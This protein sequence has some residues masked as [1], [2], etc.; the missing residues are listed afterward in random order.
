MKKYIL[1]KIK[2]LKDL[3]Y[4]ILECIETGSNDLSTKNNIIKNF[5]EEYKNEKNKVENTTKKIKNTHKKNLEE[6]KYDWIED[7]IEFD[8]R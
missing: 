4:E 3:I 1:T 7:T 8:S 2:L 5:L 6:E